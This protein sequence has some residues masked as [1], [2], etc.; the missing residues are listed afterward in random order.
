MGDGIELHPELKNQGTNFLRTP[1]SVEKLCG[2]MSM[3]HECDEKFSFCHSWEFHWLLLDCVKYLY[4]YDQQQIQW[5]N[6]PF[7]AF[8]KNL[9]NIW[10]HNQHLIQHWSLGACGEGG[11]IF[12]ATQHKSGGLEISISRG[13]LIFQMRGGDSRKAFCINSKEIK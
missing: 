3:L 2:H 13:L 8:H 10:L 1:T 4:I 9:K 7:C 5:T 12:C 11:D 6:H